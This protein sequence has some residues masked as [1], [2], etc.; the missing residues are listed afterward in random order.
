[1][2]RTQINTSGMKV[3]LL[4]TGNIVINIL[5]AISTENTTKEDIPNLIEKT[6]AVMS[7]FFEQL[8]MKNDVETS[9]NNSN[10][11]LKAS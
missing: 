2:V 9:N 8:C 5:P 4:F 3:I 1:M 7:E 6:H 10:S 11:K